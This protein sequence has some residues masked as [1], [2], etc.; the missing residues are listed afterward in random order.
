MSSVTAEDEPNCLPMCSLCA[1]KPPSSLVLSALKRCGQCKLRTYCGK[2]CQVLDWKMAGHKQTCCIQG[3]SNN[4]GTSPL[5]HKNS[6]THE[7]WSCAYLDRD[8]EIEHTC[9]VEMGKV[10]TNPSE[11]IPTGL[12]TCIF[13]VIKTKT[14]RMI[15]WHA[16]GPLITT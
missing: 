16:S 8:P 12:N 1:K 6:S 4:H 2:K 3:E 5:H 10:K 11:L 14:S 7:P 15:G 9:L 13:V